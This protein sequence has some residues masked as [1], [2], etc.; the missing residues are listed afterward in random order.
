MVL[1][2]FAVRRQNA[3]VRDVAFP[4]DVQLNEVGDNQAFR[5]APVLCESKPDE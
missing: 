2:N 4:I 3:R 1:T 5:P